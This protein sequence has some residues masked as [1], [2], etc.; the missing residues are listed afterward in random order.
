MD[1]CWPITVVE[2][3]RASRKPAT[4]GAKPSSSNAPTLSL[5]VSPCSDPAQIAMYTE[6]GS[7]FCARLCASATD[8]NHAPAICLPFVN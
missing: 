3:S 4:C 2:R 6:S 5:S 8:S 7:R 1:T